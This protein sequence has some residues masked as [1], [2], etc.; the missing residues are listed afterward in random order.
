VSTI[1]R[2]TKFWLGLHSHDSRPA[3]TVDATI[4]ARRRDSR[5]LRRVRRHAARHRRHGARP[6]R[7]ISPRPREHPRG[8]LLPRQRR[9]IAATPSV[10]GQMSLAGPDPDP[11]GGPLSQRG[12]VGVAHPVRR[13]QGRRTPVN[14]GQSEA[15]APAPGFAHRLS[16]SAIARCDGGAPLR[17]WPHRHTARIRKEGRTCNRT[18]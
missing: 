1:I 4:P 12:G 6:S 2:S 16:R 11:L 3:G 13:A 15:R 8:E 17:P 10:P 7:A 18:R 9:G 5:Q 14:P